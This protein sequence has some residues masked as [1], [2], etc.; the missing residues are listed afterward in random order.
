MRQI[1]SPPLVDVEKHYASVLET[2]SPHD[3]EPFCPAD[4]CDIFQP[5]SSDDVAKAKTN[6]RPSAPGP[7]GIRVQ[8]LLHHSNEELALLF[9]VVLWTNT[10]PSSW[11]ISR[12][13]LIPKKVTLPTY[14]IGDPS[15]LAR[16]YN[17]SFTEC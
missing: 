13:T 14:T 5:V 8:N 9:S 16:R 15:Q 3:D 1:S 7:D 17:D 6:W 2:P 11:L 4:E 12:T 10:I